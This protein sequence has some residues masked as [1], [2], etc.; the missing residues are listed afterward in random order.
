MSRYRVN[1]VKRMHSIVEGVLPL[2]EEIAAHPAVSQVTPGRIN[3]KR[4]GTDRRL[5]FQYL[6]D[7]GFKLMAHTPQAV[8]EVFVVTAAPDD[9]LAYLTE[10]KLLP[11]R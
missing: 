7:S 11:P 1:K 6:T 10:R 4:R 5:A 8:Q 3:Q 2:L 9:V